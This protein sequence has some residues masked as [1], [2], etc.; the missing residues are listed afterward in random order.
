[1][2][3]KKLFP[4][5]ITNGYFHFFIFFLSII[6]CLIIVSYLLH[7]KNKLNS[8]LFAQKKINS[9]DLLTE[10]I[11][12]TNLNYLKASLQ[13]KQEYLYR[14]KY[15]DRQ[16]VEDFI[17]QELPYQL[18]SVEKS[19]SAAGY[20]DFF[21]F[22]FQLFVPTNQEGSTSLI[23]VN[24]LDNSKLK[25]VY[26]SADDP[27]LKKYH[28]NL[29]T[30]HYF[31]NQTV[32]GIPV[33]GATLAIHIKNDQDIYGIDTNLI[34]DFSIPSSKIDQVKVKEIALGEARNQVEPKIQVEVARTE[35][36]VINKALLG[37][38]ED[39]TSYLTTAVYVLSTED[40]SNFAKKYFINLTDGKIVYQE[41]LIISNLNRIVGQY[42]NS[43]SRTPIQERRENQAPVN[44]S[45]VDVT[46]DILGDVYNFY[47]NNLN[48]DSYDNVGGVM[49]TRVLSSNCHN[50]YWDSYANT[51]TFCFGFNVKDIIG[52]E[53]THGV[54]QYTANLI[55]QYQSGTINES[56]SD[57]FGSQIDNNWTLGEDTGSGAF[58]DMADPPRLG[59]PDRL[60]SHNYHCRSSDNGGVH[61][62]DGILNK[63]FYL[64]SQGGNFNNCQ[65]NG[66][67]ATKS[68]LIV[69]RALTAYLSPTANFKNSYD[70]LN[71][72][73][74]D[75]YGNGSSTCINVNNAL[76]AT[77]INQQPATSQI[78]PLCKGQTPQPASCI[79]NPPILT[80]T[81]IGT[82]TTT[83]TSTITPAPTIST[84][85]TI[86]PVSPTNTPTP[87]LWPK[88]SAP[89]PEVI[90]IPGYEQCTRCCIKDQKCGYPS[91]ECTANEKRIRW[92]SYDC[93]GNRC[94]TM[95]LP[96]QDFI[97]CPAGMGPK[98]IRLSCVSDG[99]C[100]D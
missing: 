1:M 30:K 22:V 14:S 83:P 43:G 68:L 35:N 20:P 25:R 27:I 51:M 16:A 69:Y 81:P 23:P 95:K 7:Q 53:F 13:S 17:R 9:N 78:S 48:R 77:E 11:S 86:S 91:G 92:F 34:K 4:K 41:D 88:P 71:E 37:L 87:T 33:Y 52:H 67:G 62:N 55:Y 54:T 31:Y 15:K 2:R 3:L 63:T 94:S 28:I 80:E 66:I 93:T 6:L 96:G 58:R 12:P 42:S 10:Y 38:S 60:F 84:N 44:N 85:P 65:I 59:Q 21:H 61:Y 47:R 24:F 46:F 70:A 50:A 74:N 64:M 72:A 99:K 79:N 82:P 19:N 49:N 8:L 26:D 90:D 75:L 39:Q 57:I 36:F 76:Q 97:V 73:C 100:F 18:S 45:Q 56:M 32:Q 5:F 89:P 40:N 98:N 29:S